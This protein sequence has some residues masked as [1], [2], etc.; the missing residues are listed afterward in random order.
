MGCDLYCWKKTNSHRSSDK[1]FI[2]PWG[3]LEPIL[4]TM[5][6]GFLMTDAGFIQGFLFFC[7]CTFIIEL[8]Y[9]QIFPCFLQICL[10]FAYT[11]WS[12]FLILFFI[13]SHIFISLACA[14]ILSFLHSRCCIFGKPN[15]NASNFNRIM[16]WIC[17]PSLLLSLFSLYFKHWL[18]CHLTHATSL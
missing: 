9:P 15:A 3:S 4:R 5:G 13:V 16:Y 2:D 8:Y 17:Y 1:C 10:H 12:L 14:Y 6:L 11:S 7:N 18:L